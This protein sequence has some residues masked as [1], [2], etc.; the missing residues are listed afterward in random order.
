MKALSLLIFS[1][2][3]LVL[4]G[5]NYSYSPPTSVQFDRFF[6]AAYESDTL[7][8]PSGENVSS[9]NLSLQKESNERHPRVVLAW[10]YEGPVEYFLSLSKSEQDLRFLSEIVIQFADSVAW[11]NDYYLYVQMWHSESSLRIVFDYEKD[12]FYF[13]NNLPLLRQTISLFH[14]IN[15]MEILEMNGGERFLNQ[16]GVVSVR[17][18]KSEIDTTAWKSKFGADKAVFV[19]DGEFISFD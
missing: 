16:A 3:F 4:A 6:E 5:C 19:H 18:K 7:S 13:P 14:T 10:F 17:H 1:N 8:L 9:A 12:T 2:C 11:N 15:P